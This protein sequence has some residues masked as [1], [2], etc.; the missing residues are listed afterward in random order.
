MRFRLVN[1]ILWLAARGRS[2]PEATKL[3]PREWHARGYIPCSD[4][5]IVIQVPVRGVGFCFASSKT[6][7][8]ARMC[9]SGP[10]DQP[11]EIPAASPSRGAASVRQAPVGTS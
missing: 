5:A 3:G 8:G 9:H 2:D 10:A 11:L 1:S 4:M 7:A 6:D